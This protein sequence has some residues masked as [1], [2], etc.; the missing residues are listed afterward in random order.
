M[1]AV[2]N[3]N[4]RPLFL[5]SLPL[6]TSLYPLPLSSP[7]PLLPSSLPPLFPSS[8]LPPCLPQPLQVQRAQVKEGSFWAV[9]NEEVFA[10]NEFFQE[11]EKT[12]ATGRGV[13]MCAYVCVC[14]CVCMCVCMCAYV[15]ACVCASVHACVHMCV[16][17]CACVYTC[18]HACVRTCVCV[19][20]SRRCNILLTRRCGSLIVIERYAYQLVPHHSS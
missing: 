6:L 11:L 18:M 14:A 7:P 1:L 8:P 19:C 3:S 9:A 13:C 5:S 17:V 4:L 10:S 2:Q 15:R 16:Y 20:A 12:F